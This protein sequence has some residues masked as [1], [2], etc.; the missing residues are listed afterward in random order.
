[1]TDIEIPL[2][3]DRHFRYRLFEILPG[4]VTWTVLLL[5]IV[6]SFVNPTLAAAF[7]LI[8]FLINFIRIVAIA[9]QGLQGH[10]MMQ[11]YERLNWQQL[12]SELEAGKIDSVRIKRPK[13]HYR[14]LQRFVTHPKVVEPS[15]IVHAVIIATLN[16]AREVLEPTV[17]S[18]LAAHYDNKK[19]ILIIAYEERGGAATE[20]LA[21]NLI[22]EYGQPF[23]HAMAI[24]H[25]KDIP[26]EIIGKG[27]NITYAGYKLRD[28]LAEQQIDPLRVAVTTLDADNR[29][30]K[31]YFGVLSYAYSACEDPKR[32]SFQPVCVYTNNIWDAPA[33]MRVVATGN[34]IVNMVGSLRPHALRNF[35]SH[36]QSMAG[37]IATNFWSRRTIVEDGHQFWRSYFSFDGQ[38]QVYPLYIPIY[39]DAVLSESYFK[40][41]RAQF[42]Q[43]SRWT[44]GVTD[45]AYIMNQ[46]FC[47][48]NKVP[49]LDLLAKLWRHLELNINWA[50]GALFVTVA[51]YLPA[52]INPGSFTANELPVI[53]GNIQSYAII[54]AIVSV[55]LT[56]R[57]LPPK[58]ARYKRRRTVFMIAQWVYLPITSIVYNSLAALYSQTR[59]MLGLYIDRFD[60]TTKAVVTE[61]KRVIV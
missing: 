6:L 42:R 10:Q 5:P 23:M 54:G 14:T 19:I 56:L 36:A 32:S 13:W 47:K 39:Q 4:T 52:L 37:L 16:E 53:V 45:V 28:Y 38:Y 7:I 51:G 34:S 40:T 15:Q 61:D 35:S 46:G 22:K 33:P 60:V 21:N 3:K 8:Y 59:L 44:W 58:P 29:P 31:E 55:F 17:Q 24:K 30:H 20:E 27:S 57:T 41:L 18:V 2:E 49:R 1:M 43:L 26:D 50:A 9:V 25:P 48:K 11:Q 12:L